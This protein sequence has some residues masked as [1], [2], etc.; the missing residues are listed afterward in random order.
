LVRSRD[1]VRKPGLTPNRAA[2]VVFGITRQSDAAQKD[3][4]MAMRVR[5]P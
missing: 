3:V 2:D 5:A 1:L 4:Q